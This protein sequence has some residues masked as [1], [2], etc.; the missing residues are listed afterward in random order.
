MASVSFAAG[1]ATYEQFLEARHPVDAVSFR[2]SGGRT[3]LFDSVANKAISARIAITHRL[4]D[5][6]A[7]PSVESAGINVLHVLFGRR[8]HDAQREA[9]M[10]QRLL[11]GGADINL[12]SPRFG[13]PLIGLAKNGP[14]PETARVPLYDL[15]FDRPDLDLSL[16]SGTAGKSL[17]EF[18]LA[19]SGMPLLHEKIQQFDRRRRSPEREHCNGL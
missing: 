10:V 4:L 15:I 14:R 16:P 11:D 9:P 6:G 5:D 18:V 13:P 8:G 7:D 3:L 19:H 17:R 1:S 12:V 2:K